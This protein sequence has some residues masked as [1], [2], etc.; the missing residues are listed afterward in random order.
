MNV[1]ILSVAVLVNVI[2]PLVLYDSDLVSITEMVCRA[3]VA[4]RCKIWFLCLVKS[5]KTKNPMEG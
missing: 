4:T 5:V 3:S 2:E 1:A